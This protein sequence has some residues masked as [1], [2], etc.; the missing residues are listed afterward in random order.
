M[1]IWSGEIFFIQMISNAIN[2]VNEDV[3]R[4]QRLF[5][6]NYVFFKRDDGSLLISFYLSE[7]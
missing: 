3:A 4:K 5:Y 7:E 1:V 2:L 6:N